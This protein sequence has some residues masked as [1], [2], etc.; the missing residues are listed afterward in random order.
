MAQSVPSGSRLVIESWD[1]NPRTPSC[2][3]RPPGMTGK[4]SGR[5]STLFRGVKD[6]GA[7]TEVDSSPY[8]NIRTM[9]PHLFFPEKP[10]IQIFQVNV[11]G[12]FKYR[13]PMEKTNTETHLSTFSDPMKPACGLHV[14]MSQPCATS[15]LMTTHEQQFMTRWC[16]PTCLLSHDFLWPEAQ[17]PALLDG[18][19]QRHS[20]LHGGTRAPLWEG[21]WGCWDWFYP[22]NWGAPS[23]LLHCPQLPV[24]DSASSSAK[25]G[26]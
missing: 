10:E 6:S 25:E 2:A 1:H 17:T 9:M 8:R 5:L 22:K 7:A 13:K 16:P 20:P 4:N 23:H 21:G 19:R 24:R 3:H 15:N 12:V 14:P 18:E 11:L 26:F